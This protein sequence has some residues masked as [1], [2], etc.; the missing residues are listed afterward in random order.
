MS[1]TPT[2]KIKAESLSAELRDRSARMERIIDQL[3]KDLHQTMKEAGN[4]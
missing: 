2:W 3:N 1:H 4:G